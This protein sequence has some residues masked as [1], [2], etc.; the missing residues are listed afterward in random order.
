MLVSNEAEIEQLLLEVSTHPHI[1]M[2]WIRDNGELYLAE[3]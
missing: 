2:A 3:D 1:D